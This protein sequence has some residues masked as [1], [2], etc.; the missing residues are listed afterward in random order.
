MSDTDVNTSKSSSSN[1][2][3]Q[4]IHLYYHGLR[5]K[6]VSFFLSVVDSDHL[7]MYLTVD[8]YNTNC[9][10]LHTQCC[11]ATEVAAAPGVEEF[12]LLFIPLYW[13]YRRILDIVT[14]W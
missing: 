13:R 12:L 8:I 3:R 7:I 14:Y 4:L 5:T 10:H 2:E 11:V 1:K 9:F 6:T